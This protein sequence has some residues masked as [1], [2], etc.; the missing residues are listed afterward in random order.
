MPLRSFNSGKGGF[1]LPFLPWLI[2]SL[3]LTVTY[4]GHDIAQQ[5]TKEVLQEEF[6][7]RFNETV[8]NIER[9]LSGYDLVLRG[10]AGL[11]VA[12]ESVE[13]DE[14]R[15]YVSALNLESRYPGL[16]GVGYSLLVAPDDKERHIAETR[17]E[18]F[19]GYA[20][21][22]EGKR[23]AYTTIIY[24]EPF[25]WRNQRAFGF[26]MYSEPIR[27]AA[28]MRARDE[29]QVIV[30]G[31]VTLLQETDK[32][33][34]AGFLMY[35]PVYRN[36]VT[37]DALESRRANLMG[38]VYAPFR[39]NDLMRGILGE[40]V[41]EAR[42]ALD[43]EIYDGDTPST[44]SLM[45]DT[46]GKIEF[47]S[48]SPRSAFQSARTISVG[49]R[50]WTIALSSLPGFE[51][52]LKSD[53]ARLIVVAGAAISLLLATIVWLLISGRARALAVAT[54]M[55]RE[56]S[57]SESRLKALFEHMSSGAVVYQAT[58]DGREFFIT[59]FNRA[60]EKIDKVRR[61]DLIGKNVVAVFP[62]VVE[63]GLI[64]VLRRVWKS[65]V[66]EPFPVAWYQDERIAGWRENH[67]YKLP[68]G[69]VVAIYDDV[70]ERKQAESTLLKSFQEIEDLYHNAPCGYHSLDKEGVFL[71]I[72][73]TELGWLGYTREEIVGRLRLPDVLSP[74]SVRTF[75]ESYPV[76]MQRGWVK[77]LELEL[78]RKDG[79]VL[80]VL[81]SATAIRD[82]DGNYLMSRSTMFDITVRKRAERALQAGERHTR[83]LL[84]NLT[85]GVVVHAPDGSIS[86]TNL[87]AQT[88]FRLS[89]EVL[90]ARTVPDLTWRLLREDGS[91]MNPDEWPT[92]KVLASRQPLKNYVVG[93]A[94]N[95][96]EETRWALVNAFPDFDASGAVIQVVVSFL[97][98]TERILAKA[99]LHNAKAELEHILNVNPAVTYQ[100]KLGSNSTLFRSQ[101]VVDM[102]GYALEDWQDPGFWLSH[103]HPDDR[104]KALMAQ[105]QLLE[106][107]TL[108]HEYRFRHQDGRWVWILDRV[109]LVRDQNGMALEQVGAWLD[110]TPRKQAE[111]GLENLNRFYLVL[112]RINEAIVRTAD[113]AILF[114]NICRIVVENGGFVM[115]W[116]GMV[117]EIEGK[118]SP[119][120]YW[121]HEA[122]YLDFLQSTDLLG[123]S[124]PTCHAIKSGEFR[125]SQDIASDPHMVTWRQEAIGRGY[126]SSAAF[127]LR[128]G[129]KVVGAI[130]LYSAQPNAFDA[131]VIRLL[132]DLSA[133]IS[134]ALGALDQQARRQAAEERLRQLNEELER[135]VAERTGQ[136]EAAN[137]ELEAFSYSVSHDL[138]A[139]LR[140]IDGFSEILEKRYAERLDDSGRDYLGRV[141]RASQ[142][143]GELID[144]LLLLARMTRAELRKEPVDLS[145]M[146]RSMAREMQEAEPQRRVEWVIQDGVLA[147]AD[148]RLIKVVLENLLG[149][150]W[151]FTARQIE[152]RIEFGM[153]ERET[154]K[155]IFVRDNGAGFDMQ[156][157]GK[158]FGAFQRLHTADEFEGTGIGLATVQRIIHRHGGRV[159]AE[160]Q[161]GAGAAFYFTL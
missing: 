59:A 39:V 26:D 111:I 76:F 20:I 16:Q 91:V 152:P 129:G 109:N 132:N 71:Q 97:D 62:G 145:R 118:I 68:D 42:G 12:S 95:A 1:F 78:L 157:V 54:G 18:G 98:I 149:N 2:L 151:K 9:R 96:Q 130:N 8:A 133:D 86:Y 135:R 114:E 38:W 57:A 79:T 126:H 138:R 104:E 85:A 43:L 28:M 110:I 73:N 107:G 150:A 103:V 82:D 61:E 4:I 158:L 127:P 92:R 102:L 131:E 121:G 101:G 122:G 81:L 35:V 117:D 30:S 11:F 17:R 69:A 45:Y 136:L 5:H 65:G 33:K 155:V 146:V 34:Q 139:P 52:R 89:G 106:N 124:G 128:E 159:W 123:S 22:P 99:Q 55:T 41:R 6:K 75:H 50:D 25:D 51:S 72:N 148:S 119:S 46:N 94:L 29:N 64:D 84:D 32:D 161:S 3:G 74:A 141:R 53:K 13:R 140:S 143:M 83:Q 144:D 90:N 115:A 67:V 80:P 154:E 100:I 63:F 7:F 134:F 137:K 48:A 160:G 88:F 14:F 40:H 15:K 31:K 116:I 142:R 108:Q 47:L 23:D 70:T 49:G 24:I 93:V 113:R 147:Q 37:L 120:A 125:I 153:I 10:A 105:N 87:A 60:A 36:D 156:Y 19:A 66:A 27:R 21:R 58:P 44:E 112:S 56:L 77:D